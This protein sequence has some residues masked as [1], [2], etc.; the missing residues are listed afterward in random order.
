M[1]F[2]IVNDTSENKQ[3]FRVLNHGIKSTKLLNLLIL[4]AFEQFYFLEFNLRFVIM[5]FKREK[6]NNG[7]L[8][9]SKI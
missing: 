6:K 8:L 2:K 4:F 7:G 1:I 9:I 3:F 5:L